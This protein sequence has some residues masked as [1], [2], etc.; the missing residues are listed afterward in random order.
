MPV[1]RTHVS[2]NEAERQ[3]LRAQVRA[4]R[5][6]MRSVLGLRQWLGPRPRAWAGVQQTDRVGIDGRV[7]HGRPWAA[8]N[9]RRREEGMSP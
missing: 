6:A 8:V 5:G 7:V 9:S 1:D 4:A 2:E 3:R